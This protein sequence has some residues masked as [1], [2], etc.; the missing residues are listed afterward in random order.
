MIFARLLGKRMDAHNFFTGPVVQSLEIRRLLSASFARVSSH[1][2]LLVFGD[3]QPNNISV[4]SSASEIVASVDGSE[5]AFATAPV[6][7]ILISGGGGD[8]TLGD[9]THLRPIHIG[10]LTPSCTLLG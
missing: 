8:D 1:G 10:S 7:R 9:F 2:T 4:R 3:D 6:K 5:F